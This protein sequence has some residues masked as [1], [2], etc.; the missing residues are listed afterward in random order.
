M[1]EYLTD[2][3]RAELLRPCACGHTINDHGSLAGC[4]MC[5]DEGGDCMVAF[6]SLLLERLNVVIAR[7]CATAWELGR[8]PHDAICPLRYEDGGEC[9]CVNPYLGG[10]A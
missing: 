6:E 10:V 3:D 8:G 2:E 9:I 1:T 4:W 7:D 5:E